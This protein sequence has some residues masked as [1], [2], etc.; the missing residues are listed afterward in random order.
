[1]KIISNS[2]AETVNIGKALGEL[3]QP[4]GVIC[5][6]GNLGAGKT[7][8]AKGIALGLGVTDHVTSP[9][10]TIINEYEGRM[11]FYHVDVYRLEDEEEA[12][13]IG[14]EEYLY[15]TGITLIEW[16]ARIVGLLPAERL[17]ITITSAEAQDSRIF[18]FEARGPG[19]TKLVEELNAHVRSGN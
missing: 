13:E 14:L 1:M 2:P 6:E 3:L 11:P 15:G 18:Q 12:Y 10:F 9:T 5:L 7:H 4:G 19:Y 8:F 17:T 16:P